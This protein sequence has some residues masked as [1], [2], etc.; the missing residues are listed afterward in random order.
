M[1]LIHQTPVCPGMDDT[2]IIP[3]E[4]RPVAGFPQT[5]RTDAMFIALTKGMEAVFGIQYRVVLLVDRGALRYPRLIEQKADLL[6]QLRGCFN[7][8]IAVC[9]KIIF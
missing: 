8:D 2:V 9:V 5:H 3:L 6:N 1:R 7:M 4:F